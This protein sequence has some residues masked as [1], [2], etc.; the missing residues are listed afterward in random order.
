MMKWAQLYWKT[1]GTHDLVNLTNQ[2]SITITAQK[3]LR[4]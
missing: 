4:P 3:N 2:L 1:V